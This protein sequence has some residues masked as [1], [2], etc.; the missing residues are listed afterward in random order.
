[1]G[2]IRIA[3]VGLGLIGRERLRAVRRLRAEGL[4]IDIVALLDPFAADIAALAYEEGASV[5]RKLEDV[6][7]C[8][9]DLT[10]VAVPHDAA[11]ETAGALM[12]TGL[13]ILLEKP[14]GRDL[15]EARAIAQLQQFDRQLSIGHNYR[16]FAGVAALVDDARRGIFGTPIGLTLVLGHGGSPADQ[17]SWKLDPV[18]AGGGCLIDPGIHLID[19]TVLLNGGLA[20]VAG[21]H[22][23]RGFWNTGIEEDCH[24]I[25][26]GGSI[27]SIDLHV[28]VVRWRSTFRVEFHGMDGYGIVE[29]RGRS[30]GPQTYRRGKRWGWQGGP[31]QAES[32]E[33]VV[34]SSADDAFAAELRDILFGDPCRAASAQES[35]LNMEL[36]DDCRAALNLNTRA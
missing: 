22:A 17:Q 25:L 24:L 28:S 36:L 16:F 7:V 14:L 29:G 10:V 19:L 33:L 26:T 5:C 3:I 30:Y 15:Q 2:L 35:L 21:G 4:G 9:P 34:T 20:A 8:R 1:M 6:A 32:E 13:R 31:S 11:A 12:N 18:R 23:W 27:P